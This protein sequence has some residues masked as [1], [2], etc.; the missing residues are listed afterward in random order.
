MKEYDLTRTNGIGEVFNFKYFFDADVDSAGHIDVEGVDIYD[1]NDE[2]LCSVN[3]VLPDTIDE[4][5]TIE[6]DEFI[7]KYVN[8]IEF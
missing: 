3:F 7:D 2:W 5:N 4:L 8:Q 1:E 6:F